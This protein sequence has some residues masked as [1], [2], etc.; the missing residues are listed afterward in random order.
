MIA[1]QTWGRQAAVAARGMAWS[2]AR[3]LLDLLLPP[4]CLTCDQAVAEPGLLCPACFAATKFVGTPCCDHCGCGFTHVDRGAVVDGRAWPV[5]VACAGNPPP[6]QQARA[7]LGYDAQAKRLVLGFK[8]GDRP[9]LAGALAGMMH[10]AGAAL[11]QRAEVI[12]PVPLHR[13]RLLARRYNQ[14]AL[15]ALALQRLSGRPAVPDLLRRTH[16]TVPLGHLGAMQREAVVAGVFVVRPHRAAR[17]VGRR[18]LLVDDVMTT[19]ATAAAC[20]L[21]LLAA[22]AASVD[23]L[24]A[25]RVPD[26]RVLNHRRA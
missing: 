11:A 13:R 2:A 1:L 9:E 3:R 16:H 21:A 20:T 5:C 24:V 17:V 8:Y 4:E 22:G 19:G 12:V 14:A 15:L 23:V 18:V 10:R 6:W 26:P 25:A 7:P